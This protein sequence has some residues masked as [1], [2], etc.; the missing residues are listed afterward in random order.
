MSNIYL[1]GLKKTCL[2]VLDRGEQGDDNG[3]SLKEGEEL[4]MSNYSAFH[5]T[6]CT[7]SF[8]FE[9]LPSS[10]ILTSSSA[11]SFSF[12]KPCRVLLTPFNLSLVN[13]A[14]RSAM[15][16]S[17]SIFEI[18]VARAKKSYLSFS[19]PF[20]NFLDVSWSKTQQGLPT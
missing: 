19:L 13:L 6:R 5:N 9:Y 8:A 12:N 15:F 3:T 14:V 1:I 18:K 11:F 4:E 16:N 20:K 2:G 7:L 17:R 10:N